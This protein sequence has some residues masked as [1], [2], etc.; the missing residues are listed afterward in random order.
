M[1]TWGP[2]IYSNDTAEDVRDLCYE[3][4]PYLDRAESE[5]ILF[6]EFKDTLRHPDEDDDDYASFWYGYAA[7]LWKYGML[8]DEVRDKTLALLENYAG[9]A[10][11][12]ESAA[13]SDVKKRK[14]ALDKLRE[15]LLSP[16]PPTKLPRPAIQR[17]KNKP[18]SSSKRSPKGTTRLSDG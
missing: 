2:G 17:P 14:A 7:W 9:I 15:K 6:E 1:G 11:W 13:P 4:F 18:F 10:M 3:L 16:Q 8:T 12:E 5:R